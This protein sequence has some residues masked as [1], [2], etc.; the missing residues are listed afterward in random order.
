MFVMLTRCTSPLNDPSWPIEPTIVNAAQALY[1]MPYQDDPPVC[2]VVFTGGAT[3]PVAGDIQSL[4]LLIAG[5][6]SGELRDVPF[7]DDADDPN[8]IVRCGGYGCGA[9]MPRKNAIE[10]EID[11]RPAWRCQECVEMIQAGP[12]DDEL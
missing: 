3:L 6:P 10:G 5:D 2:T 12:D 9:P 1:I 11:G 8:E 4:M 7:L